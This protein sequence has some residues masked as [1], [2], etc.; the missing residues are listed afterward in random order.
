MIKYKILLTIVK[1]IN[2]IYV[3]P[4]YVGGQNIPKSGAY[5]LAGNHIHLLDPGPIMSVINRNIHFLAKASLF[6]FP[7]SLIFNNMGLIPVNRD[8]KDRDA[9]EKA[10]E[11]LNKGEIIGIYPEGTRERGR[12]LLP[13]KTGAVRM[14]YETNTPIIPFATIGKYKPFKKGLIVRFG[15]PYKVGKDIN[16]ANDELREIIRKLR[17]E[18]VI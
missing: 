10:I 6:K 12:G 16:K 3:R 9:Y 7:Q 4:K 1:F 11:C 5:I 2:K 14:A 17:D 13:F 8:N 15:M 18:Y